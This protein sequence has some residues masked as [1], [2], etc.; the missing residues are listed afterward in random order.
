MPPVRIAMSW[1]MALRRSP[2]PGALTGRDLQTMPR[3][4]VDHQG[5]QR[6][7]FDVLGNDH[8]RL[9]RPWINLTPAAGSSSADVDEIF[10]STSSRITESSSSAV[11]LSWL[12]MK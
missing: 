8:Q 6:F 9:L 11:M 2:K 10:L 5:S 7:A 1:S 3:M 4:L 12:L